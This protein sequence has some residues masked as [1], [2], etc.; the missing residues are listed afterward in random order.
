MGKSVTRIDGDGLL[1]PLARAD[2][3]EEPQPREALGVQP[4]RLGIGRERGPYGHGLRRGHRRQPE[5][6]AQARTRARD[7][8]VQIR[9]GSLLRDKSDRF[10]RRGVLEAKVEAER[11]AGVAAGSQIRAEENEIRA[12]VRPHARERVAGQRVRVGKREV[13]LHA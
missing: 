6:L 7:D 9:L 8:G 1:E 4:R 3:V 10:A 2:L 13:D 12:Q 5:L 11:A